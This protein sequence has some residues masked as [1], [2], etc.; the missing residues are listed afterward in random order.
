MP[1]KLPSLDP[2]LQI[3]FSKSLDL[4]RELYLDD[5]LRKTIESADLKMIEKELHS[6]LDENILKKVASFGIRGEMFFPTK[7]LLLKNPKLLGYYRLLYGFS[8]KEL[9]SKSGLGRFKRMEEDGSIGKLSPAD[10]ADFIKVLCAAG[11]KLAK[12][13]QK[14]SIQLV[15]EL[16]LLRNL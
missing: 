9:Y 12:T 11:S 13:C 1:A 15:N 8:Q 5:A 16:Q 14:I 10:I 2:S 6:V 4:I 3:K 7:S